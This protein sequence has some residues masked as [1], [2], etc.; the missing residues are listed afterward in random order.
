MI[1][2]DS[3]SLVIPQ[4]FGNYISHQVIGQGST[5]IVIEAT[6]RSSGKDYAVKVMS[7]SDLAAHNLIKKINREISIL[8]SLTHPNIVRFHDFIRQDDLLFLITENCTGGDL[9]TWITEGRTTDEQ[10]RK[11]LFHDVVV[12]VQHLHQ[13]G[14]AHNDIKPENAIIDSS[15]RAKLADFGYAK[16]QTFADDNEK[17]GTLM[18]A[19]PELF[20]PGRYHTQKADLWSLGILLYAM[21]TGKFPFNGR[22]DH[23]IVRQICRG[24][25]MYTDDIDPEVKRLVRQLTKVNPNERPTIDE[26][27]EDSFFDDVRMVCP[28]IAESE[29]LSECEMKVETDLVA[30]AHMW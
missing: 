3:L 2:T 13:Q 8:R 26:L 7:S 12:G 14:I 25:L 30:E 4:H 29:R 20:R 6:D 19:A 28:K 16:T 22:T 18:Y 17:S 15:G 23:D 21:A 11:R 1:D 5:C 9:L 27:L 24:D 10:T